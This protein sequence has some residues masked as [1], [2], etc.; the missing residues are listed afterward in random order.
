MKNIL[1]TLPLLFLAATSVVTAQGSLG[2]GNGY[3]DDGPQPD[4]LNGSNFTYPYP[5]KVYNF[6]SQR[7]NMQMAFMDVAPANTANTST[8]A[9]VAVLL[10]GKNFCGATWNET[11]IQLTGVGYRVIAPD[12]VG[13]LKQLGIYNATIIGHSTGGMLAARY[14][15]MYPSNTTAMAM[16]NPLGLEDWKTRGVPYQSVDR[17]WATENATTYASIKAYENTT[18]YVGRWQ[19]QYDVWVGMLYNVYTGTRR[20]EFTYNQAQTTDM[21]YTQPVI[22]EFGLLG[23]QVRTL[24]VIGDRDNTAIGKAWSPPAVQA[25]IGN[26]SVLGPAAAAMIPNST[27]VQFP[28]LGHAPQIEE[29]A[30][31]HRELFGWLLDS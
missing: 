9:P 7:L 27:L 20:A 18:Y 17:S 3:I 13:L 21:I 26:Y 29:P 15:L 19:P 5:V 23:Q 11:I 16:V 8:E 24:L 12:Q 30:E 2:G 10:H 28:D 1:R 6:P 14:A 25:V 4:D 31:F 22:Y